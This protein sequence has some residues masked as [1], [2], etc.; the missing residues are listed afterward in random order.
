MKYQKKERKKKEAKMKKCTYGGKV[1]RLS[2]KENII[3]AL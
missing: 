2:K 3:K 1:R